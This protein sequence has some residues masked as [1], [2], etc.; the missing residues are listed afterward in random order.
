MANSLRLT[1]NGGCE[2][3]D[4]TTARTGKRYYC[5]IVQADTVVGTLTGGLAGDTTTNY[6]TSIGLGSK[7]LK[8]GAI[9]Y[10]P[11][12]AFFTNLTLTSGSIIAYSE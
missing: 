11:G 8:Q 1:A 2:Y 6:L 10:A 5:F 7:T 9:I 3:I 12:D 4:N